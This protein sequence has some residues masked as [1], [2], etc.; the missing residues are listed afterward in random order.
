MPVSDSDPKLLKQIDAF[1]VNHQKVREVESQDCHTV[2]IQY[3]PL[4]NQG[5]ALAN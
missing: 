2:L 4:V 3:S 1:F 5:P